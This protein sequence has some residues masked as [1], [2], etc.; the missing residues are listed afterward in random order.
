M[1][2]SG[3]NGEH[4]DVDEAAD[5]EAAAIAALDHGADAEDTEQALVLFT[6]G[7]AMATLALCS[8][9]AALRE[10]LER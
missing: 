10:V 3:P 9:L 1:M 2:G 7:Q 5:R 6:Q 4:T 8:Q